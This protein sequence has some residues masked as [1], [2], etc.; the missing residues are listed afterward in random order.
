MPTR[1]FIDNFV[2]PD[3][4]VSLMKFFD[5]NDHLCDDG[6]AFHKDRN[7]HFNNIPDPQIRNLLN[8]YAHKN[9]MFIDHHFVTKT[10]QWQSMRMCRWLEG[11]F[12]PLHVDRQLENNDTMDYSSLVYLNDNYTGGELFFKNE[13][14]TEEVFKMKAL[15]C[16]VFDSGK[17]NGHGVKKVLG[18]RR[19]T[20]PSW[21]QNV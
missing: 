16:I 7:I 5:E 11:H 6:R 14:G 3:D 10:K 13:D 19:Y 1:V 18:G 17:S 21:Y 20:I 2:H 8:Y 15:S 9:I 12:M 4:A